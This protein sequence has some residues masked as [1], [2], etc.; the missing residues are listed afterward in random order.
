M[1]SIPAGSAFSS[2]AVALRAWSC[3]QPLIVRDNVL[4][5]NMAKSPLLAAIVVPYIDV[6]ASLILLW[7]LTSEMV[8]VLSSKMTIGV[9]T[10]WRTSVKSCPK[11]AASRIASVSAASLDSVLERVTGRCR[12]DSHVT[13]VAKH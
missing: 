4:D 1:D 10:D 12:P 9:A 8:V 5:L 2:I 11:D 7:L 6:F 3:R 13:T